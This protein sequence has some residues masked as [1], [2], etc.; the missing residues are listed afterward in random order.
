MLFYSFILQGGI[1]ADADHNSSCHGLPTHMSC[2]LF[3]AFRTLRQDSRV[4]KPLN[5]KDQWNHCDSHYCTYMCVLSFTI[6]YQIFFYKFTLH[7]NVT[8][9]TDCDKPQTIYY[10]TYS[11]KHKTFVFNKIMMKSL[12][13]PMSC[14]TYK[15]LNNL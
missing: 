2:C 9:T 6:S 1:P 8:N 4:A 5:S 13:F 11:G 14:L 15:K 3:M 12:F 7:I 10:C